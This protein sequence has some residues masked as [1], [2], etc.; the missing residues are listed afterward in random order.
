MRKVLSDFLTWIEENKVKFTP[1]RMEL[2]F[3]DHPILLQETVSQRDDNVWKA[4]N[5]VAS[6]ED[7]KELGL[8]FKQDSLTGS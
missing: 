2:T 5:L 1:P 7:L 3:K 4:V 8:K 6:W